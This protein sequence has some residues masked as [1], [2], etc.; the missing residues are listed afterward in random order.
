MGISLGLTTPVLDPAQIAEF[1]A[2]GFLLVRRSLA[3]PMAATLQRWA[4]EAAALPEV[5]GRQRVHHTQCLKH[6]GHCLISGIERLTPFHEGFRQLTHA[7]TS[8]AAQL[9]G[10]PAVLLMEKLEFSLPGHPGSGPGRD[11]DDGWAYY[12]DTFVS[13]IVGIDADPA[14][15][16]CLQI[17]PR[18]HRVGLQRARA[19]LTDAEAASLVYT[20]VALAPGDLLYLDAAAPYRLLSNG[21]PG[22]CRRYRATFNRQTAGDH[23]VRYYADR[24]QN[25]PCEVGC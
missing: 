15:Q 5:P 25:E 20:G 13:V 23:Q 19:P 9:L 21:G 24:H 14:T 6:H 17:A 2:T 12:A 1:H 7:L 22:A 10:A 3:P 11:V 4:A 18:R 8:P 16:G